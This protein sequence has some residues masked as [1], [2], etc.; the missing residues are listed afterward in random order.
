MKLVLWSL[1][2]PSLGRSMILVLSFARVYE[3]MF[4]GYW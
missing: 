2:K 1:L 3:G 4:D